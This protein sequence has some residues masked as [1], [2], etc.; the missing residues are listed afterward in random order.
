[1]PTLQTTS[2]G[3]HNGYERVILVMDFPPANETWVYLI[4]D[5]RAVHYRYLYNPLRG[6]RC[7]IDVRSFRAGAGPE[8]HSILGT[9]W[10]GESRVAP[11]LR[12]LDEI[13]AF[14]EQYYQ[15]VFKEPA[16]S[17]V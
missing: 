9:G 13:W 6:G 3:T 14:L 5:G 1:M 12:S 10:W 7:P 17:L 4:R 15:E 16:D 2:L 8:E 11:D